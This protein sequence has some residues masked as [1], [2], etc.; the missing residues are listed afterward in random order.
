MRATDQRNRVTAYAFFMVVPTTGLWTM[1]RYS[2][3]SLIAEPQLALRR[4]RS[5]RR[6]QQ[7]DRELVYPTDKF[8]H[9]LLMTNDVRRCGPSGS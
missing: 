1:Q 4:E 3:A 5:V 8:T 7:F 9:D 2:K 6:S